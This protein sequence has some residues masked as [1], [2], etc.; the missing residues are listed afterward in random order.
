FPVSPTLPGPGPAVPAS[1]GSSVSAFLAYLAG[2]V[3][4]DETSEPSPI[5][6][7]FAVPEDETNDPAMQG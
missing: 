1:A 2:L 7:S 6:D 5:A 3:T 4:T